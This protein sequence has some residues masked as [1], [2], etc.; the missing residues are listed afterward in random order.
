[1]SQLLYNYIVVDICKYI[2]TIVSTFN[3]PN[4]DVSIKI[5]ALTK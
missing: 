4:V 5:W 2:V 1:M 3:H